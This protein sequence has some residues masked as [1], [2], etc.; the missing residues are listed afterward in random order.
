MAR[1]GA[2]SGVRSAAHSRSFLSR[3]MPC[4][5]S[6]DKAGNLRPRWGFI[7]AHLASRPLET[8]VITIADEG[9]TRA[10]LLPF[11][12][13]RRKPMGIPRR[14]L[15]SGLLLLVAATAEGQRSGASVRLLARELPGAADDANRQRNGR[16]RRR[17]LVHQ[18]RADPDGAH[19]RALARRADPDDHGHARKRQLLRE[20]AVHRRSRRTPESRCGA[21]PP[22][23]CAT[24]S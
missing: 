12:V 6:C 24:G 22:A 1:A 11:S 8:V 7:P 20:R 2:P 10:R 13:K 9:S 15:A 4:G 23:T 3:R 5:A 21:G 18:G 14:V 19:S 16:D 17:G